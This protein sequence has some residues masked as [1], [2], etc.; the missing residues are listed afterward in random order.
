M[1]FFCLADVQAAQEELRKTT[2]KYYVLNLRIEE[3]P[4]SKR[5]RPKGGIREIKQMQYGLLK[6]IE[7]GEPYGLHP[8]CS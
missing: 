2:C 1:D 3:R 4:K 8:L 5:G 6:T 7:E